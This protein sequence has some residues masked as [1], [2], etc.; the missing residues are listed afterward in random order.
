MN[1]HT[2]RD[3]LWYAARGRLEKKYGHVCDPMFASMAYGQFAWN[4]DE[5]AFMEMPVPRREVIRD[6][7]LFCL[8]LVVWIS[9]FIGIPLIIQGFVG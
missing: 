5:L 2:R 8:V 4:P 7:W 9:I 1:L 3:E 6:R